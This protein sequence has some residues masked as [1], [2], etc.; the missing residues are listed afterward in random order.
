MG[1][2]VPTTI[3]LEYHVYS[4]G[5]WEYNGERSNYWRRRRRAVGYDW[6]EP[7]VRSSVHSD[8][9]RTF[10]LSPDCYYVKWPGRSN[11]QCIVYGCI[12]CWRHH[13]ECH[14]CLSIRRIWFGTT[15]LHWI[16]HRL[17]HHKP[18]GPAN[19]RVHGS[20]LVQRCYFSLQH[21]FE[22]LC[23]NPCSRSNLQPCG[24]STQQQFIFAGRK[25]EYWDVQLGNDR[26][27]N[28]VHYVL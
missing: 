7:Y 5:N 11:I 12:E 16:Q 21:L 20:R 3:F 13:T 24:P 28:P 22:Q 18:F 15:E 27:I 23:S 25:C 17:F 10:N 8:Y 26:G 14:W 6:V 4:V 2:C 19:R 1:I 9:E